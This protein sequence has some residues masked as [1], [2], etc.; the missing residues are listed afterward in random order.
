MSS[1]VHEDLIYIYITLIKISHDNRAQQ[2]FLGDWTRRTF[3]RKINKSTIKR[4]KNYV[5]L[6]CLIF[7]CKKKIS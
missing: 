4:G 3:L 7:I 5:F 1:V 2:L 6:N